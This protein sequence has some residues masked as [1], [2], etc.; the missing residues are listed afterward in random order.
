MVALAGVEWPEGEYALV[1]LT[2]PGVFPADPEAWRRHLDAFRHRWERR[3]GPAE[4]AWVLEFQRRGAPHWHLVLRLPAMRIELLRRWVSVAWY[5]VVGSGDRRHLAAGT[6][7]RRADSPRGAA[8]YL[9]AELGKW[10]QKQ[11]PVGLGGA[12][13]WWGI[14]RLKRRVVREDV[15][16]SEF[17]VL[18][19][20][21]R[22]LALSRGYRSVGGR[23][24][25]LTVLAGRRARPW[26]LARAIAGW[27]D[28][29]RGTG[30][31]GPRLSVS[32]V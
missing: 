20:L 17:F 27:L 12:G 26:A 31:A 18:R 29:L 11:L 25:G 24:E 22:R 5:V 6:N 1:T 30:T 23:L 13:R 10:K 21:L 28:S 4:G 16:P 8:Q 14:W 2:Y 15:S 32:A 9:F 3:W 7:V 19:R